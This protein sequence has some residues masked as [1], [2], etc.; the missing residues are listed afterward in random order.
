[1]LE[2]QVVK[3]LDHPSIT[4][5]LGASSAFPGSRE[6]Q[7]DWT[8]GLVFELCEEGDVHQ[9]IQAK[10]KFS[11]QEKVMMAADV[12]AGI[13]YLHSKDVVHRDMSTRNLLMTN[14]GRVKI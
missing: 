14:E 12:A 5:F 4:K 7:K 10:R 9:M 11:V 13:E 1:M 2:L 3:I 6:A 8:V